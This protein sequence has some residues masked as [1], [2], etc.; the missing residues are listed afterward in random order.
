M[1]SSEANDEAA[2]L[3]HGQ[4]LVAAVERSITGW[5]EARLEDRAGRPI[6]ELGGEVDRDISAA[7]TRVIESLTTLVTAD[8]DEPLSGPL[9]RIRVAI[10]P[11]T[12]V[13]AAAGAPQTR[14]DPFDAASRPD[15]L[16]ELGPMTF[17]DL[18]EEVHEA[19]ITWGAAKAYLHRQRRDATSA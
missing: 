2:Y 5:L 8:V 13:L 4:A 18:G 14:R 7:S 6:S 9:E 12:D 17:L 11:L 16:Y 15:D 10:A 1:T 19:G 3:A